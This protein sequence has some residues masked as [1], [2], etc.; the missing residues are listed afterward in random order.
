M[1]TFIKSFVLS[2]DYMKK[3][4]I[5]KIYFSCKNGLLETIIETDTTIHRLKEEQIFTDTFTVESYLEDFFLKQGGRIEYQS[6]FGLEEDIKRMIH[7]YSTSYLG[8]YDI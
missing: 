7:A 4:I 6:K 3:G 2:A 1:D 8:V 5:R